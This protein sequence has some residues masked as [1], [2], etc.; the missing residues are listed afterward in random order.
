MMVLLLVSQSLLELKLLLHFLLL[1]GCDGAR[2][3]L[4]LPGSGSGLAVRCDHL[5]RR[6]DS[7][8]GRELRFGLRVHPLALHLL[9][10]SL[11][12]E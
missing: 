6:G 12:V 5:W 7:H 9:L 8:R 3:L 4:L 11:L 1:V 10:L 2:C